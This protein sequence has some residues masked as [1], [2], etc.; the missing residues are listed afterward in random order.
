MRQ[1]RTAEAT[2]GKA[3]EKQGHRPTFCGSVFL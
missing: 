2:P 1:G 3:T